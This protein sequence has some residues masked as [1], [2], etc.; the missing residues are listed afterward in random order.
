MIKIGLTGGI[1]SG[2]SI[3]A[4][5]LNVL[6]IPVFDSDREARA[7]IEHDQ[8]LKE[9]IVARFGDRIYPGGA[10]DRKV[11]ASIVF[12][13]AAALS[14]L[15]SMVHPAVRK[16]FSTWAD[17]QRS[18]YVVMEA[19]ILAETG[20]HS[21][22]DR[23]IVVSAPEE[24]RIR[25]VVQRDGVGEEAVRA[26]MRNQASEADRLAIADHVIVNDDKQLVMPQVL[27]IHEQLKDPIGNGSNR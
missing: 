17:Q 19:A 15:N 27:S 14:D 4:R 6:E 9:Q 10:L 13:D 5:I 26:R 25:R 1:G 24:V 2:K 16:L 3:V 7:L 11:L 22:F 12:N 20:G 18:P 21:A 23:V 8:G